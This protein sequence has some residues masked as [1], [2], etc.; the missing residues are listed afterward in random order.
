MIET[1][2]ARYRDALELAPR[3]RFEDAGEIGAT[4]DLG[5]REGLCLCLL[6]S[7]R[8]Y[9]LVESGAVIGLWG[10]SG[11]HVGGL[12]LGRPWLLAAERLFTRRR[13]IV[14]HSR[15][16]VER[17][18]LEYDALANL[19]LAS[20]AAHL[21]WLAWC[22]FR[23]LRVHRRHGSAGVPYCEFYQVNPLRHEDDESVRESLLA[24]TLGERAEVDRLLLH[25]ARFAAAGFPADALSELLDAVQV[26]HQAGGPVR[27]ALAA[28]LVEAS[29][30][31]CPSTPGADPL[32]CEWAENMRALAGTALLDRLSAAELVFTL[33]S[34]PRC[35]NPARTVGRVPE[36]S[37]RGLGG[38]DAL[39]RHYVATLTL[40]GR[41]G[42]VQGRRL[43]M[44]AIGLPETPARR[45]HGLALTELV[46]GWSRHRPF[47]DRLARGPA[48]AAARPGELV[49]RLRGA[50]ASH[51]LGRALAETL[52]RWARDA[53]AGRLHGRPMSAESA[54][55]LLAD[56][57]C[58]RLLPAP[59]SGGV[60]AGYGD[61]QQLYWLL[62]CRLLA[63][64]D[65]AAGRTVAADIGALLVA[66]RA[67]RRLLSGAPQATPEDDLAAVI[68]S[69][70]EVF[71]PEALH[72]GDDL[73]GLLGVLAPAFGLASV[74]GAQLASALLAWHL[75]LDG[76]LDE[77]LGQV[78]DVLGTDAAGSRAAYRRLLRGVSRTVNRASLQ[79]HLTGLPANVR[80][81]A[82]EPR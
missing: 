58:R 40:G 21:R 67:E 17:L 31:L 22:G 46:T 82:C 80:E 62:R 28:L 74:H 9:A 76:V 4:W 69:I 78:S 44:A 36:S 77:V 63:A 68:D 49:E 81:A 18:L 14:R 56:R 8:A 59:R 43:R 24:R 30:G 29:A 50:V 7:D 70:V 20:N 15:R 61:R 1:R 38:L 54:A 47:A 57:L 64:A 51:T 37:P 39:V 27:P 48:T 23:V 66:A 26:R 11:G 2:P 5:S 3:L 72:R 73:A 16:W 55:A 42:R 52:D 60:L 79:R 33:A 12:H 41:L 34:L 6:Q 75:L 65:T 25:A 53:A 19:T 35:T 45:P 13:E 10:V 71:G 32:L